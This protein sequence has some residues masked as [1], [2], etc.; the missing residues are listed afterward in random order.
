MSSSPQTYNPLTKKL[1]K[2][3]QTNSLKE[4]NLLETSLMKKEDTYRPRLFYSHYSDSE[5][6]E[7]FYSTHQDLLQVLYNELVFFCEEENLNSPSFDEFQL[8]S[9]QNTL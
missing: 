3:T 4:D 5:I 6:Q 9:W 1:L 7:R 2:L 8:F